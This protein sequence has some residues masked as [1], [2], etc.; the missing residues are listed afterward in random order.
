MTVPFMPFGIILS[1]FPPSTLNS[2]SIVSTPA[3]NDSSGTN[4]Y[5][6]RVTNISLT[7]TTILMAFRNSNTKI[8][9][10]TNALSA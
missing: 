3:P 2:S 7:P 6:I 4:D 10:L 5:A 8:L 9:S 1:T